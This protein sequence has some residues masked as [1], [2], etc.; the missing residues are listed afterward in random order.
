VKKKT[1]DGFTQRVLMSLV[2]DV[3]ALAENVERVQTQVFAMTK[4][5][6]N[7]YPERLT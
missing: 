7:S 2:V 5:N 6:G 4:E 1:D 3:Q